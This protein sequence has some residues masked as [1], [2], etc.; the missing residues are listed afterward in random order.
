MFTTFGTGVCSDW[1]SI[2]ISP[3][4][5][6]YTL[7][8]PT[9]LQSEEPP[10]FGELLMSTQIL[11]LTHPVQP[12]TAVLSPDDFQDLKLTETLWRLKRCSSTTGVNNIQVIQSEVWHLAPTGLCM[13]VAETDR[14]LLSLIMAKMEIRLILAE[15]HP[16]EPGQYFFH[17]QLRVVR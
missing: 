7:S 4:I 8:I 2:R 14:A 3:Q 16:A 10:P 17:P 15:I 9:M 13:S 12:A 5:R 1:Q 6:I 11:V